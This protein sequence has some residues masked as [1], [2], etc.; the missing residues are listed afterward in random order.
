MTQP[1]CRNILAALRRVI[2]CL[3]ASAQPASPHQRPASNGGRQIL[4]PTWLRWCRR[5]KIR[6]DTIVLCS[7]R[8]MKEFSAKTSRSQPLWH[9]CMD[10]WW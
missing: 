2:R 7:V 3:V 8:I 5:L 1:T 6:G 10:D 9:G 4:P